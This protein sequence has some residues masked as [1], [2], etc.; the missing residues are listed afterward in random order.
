VISQLP[1]R[2]A[3]EPP[4]EGVAAVAEEFRH[5]IKVIRK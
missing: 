2:H 3:P 5:E 4:T 1:V